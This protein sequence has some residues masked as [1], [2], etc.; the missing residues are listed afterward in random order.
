M[1]S[2]TE[3]WGWNGAGLGMRPAPEIDRSGLVAGSLIAGRYRLDEVI[4]RGGMATVW[5]G[6]DLRL[7]RDVAV[8]VCAPVSSEC[9][10]SIREER[11]S[12]T[13]LHP[14]I[15]SIFD[16]GD[17]AG[18]QADGVC[19]YIVMEYVNGTTARQLAPVPWREA[20]RIVR[21]AA[22]GLA[23]AHERGIVH[24]DVKPGNLL[25]DNRGRVLVADF[26]IA[27]PVE[28]ELGDFVHGSP[29]YLAPERLSG[30]RADPRVDVYGLG[31]ILAYLI[32]GVRPS[33]DRINLP[34]DC[35]GQI[36]GVIARSRMRDPRE[37]YE[38]ARA[39]RL[40]LDA[41]WDAN[42]T[43]RDAPPVMLDL[44]N[45][46]ASPNA[47]NP[48]RRVISHPMRA[49]P[50]PDD[51]RLPAQQTAAMSP[52]AVRRLPP[53]DARSRPRSTHRSMNRRSRASVMIAIVGLLVLFAGGIALRQ[54]VSTASVPTGPPPAAA[55]AEMPLVEGQTLATA[56][57]SLRGLGIVVERVDVID[58][59]GP[60][61]Q[62]VA[63]DPAPGSPIGDG[64]R[65]TLVVRRGR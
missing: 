24:C 12:S 60:V 51:G 5:R 21:Q 38:D 43:A 15:V 46:P 4:G 30:E 61:N 28:S 42:V 31:G 50:Y 45:W 32:T 48:T 58:G 10:R 16:A 18:N 29:A 36:A 22:D 52:S 49:H 34:P 53:P 65:V 2:A 33:D 56:I 35:P 11:L 23:A 44:N 20:A 62:V 1:Q 54:I 13:L 9:P 41:A 63:Q 25:I 37:R 57:E 59:P 14:N 26:G 3:P 27:M 6:H 55:A 17:I 40:A 19:S 47:R 7:G 8:K 39:F 64:D